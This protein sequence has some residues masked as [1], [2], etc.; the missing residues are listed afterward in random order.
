MWSASSVENQVL[1][2]TVLNYWKLDLIHLSKKIS[3]SRF[4]CGLGKFKKKSKKK[5]KK[6]NYS[7]KIF[8][9]KKISEF[10]YISRTNSWH[11]IALGSLKNLWSSQT[12]AYYMLY[13][14]SFY[15]QLASFFVPQKDSYCVHDDTEDFCLFPLQLNIDFFRAFFHLLTFSSPGRLWCF[16]HASFRSLSL[17]FW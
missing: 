10:S 14:N 5:K 8:Q 7:K 6:K 13:N 2:S 4:W 1:S 11:N 16:S 9:L 12:V 3:S 17:C 15:T